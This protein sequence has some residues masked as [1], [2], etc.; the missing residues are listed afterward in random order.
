MINRRQLMRTVGV[1]LPAAVLGGTV[2][3][4][5]TPQ[6]D[7]GTKSKTAEGCE[8]PVCTPGSGKIIQWGKAA[9]AVPEAGL[10]GVT[11]VSAGA[12]ANLY[13]LM[14]KDGRVAIWGSFNFST[15]I[16]QRLSR[17]PVAAT[18]DV[19]A[20]ATASAYSIALR[21]GGVIVW[22][23]TSDLNLT[24]PEA[25]K[26]G[27]TAI[28]G[29]NGGYGDGLF[30]KDGGVIQWHGRVDVPDEAKEGIVAIAARAHALALREDGRVITWGRDQAANMAVPAE[31]QSGVT[32]ISAGAGF[33]LAIKN[34]GV[35]A[36]G[37]NSKGQLEVPYE[38]QSDVVAISAG[39]EASMALTASGKIVT[40]AYNFN[41]Q[42]D[43]PAEAQCGGSAISCGRICMVVL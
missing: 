22:G 5:S 1:G 13:N 20:I 36:W 24:L 35:I 37:D 7:P 43:I 25:A 4:V 38:A 8:P 40:W 6:A 32:K 3:R 9:P 11:A 19:T 34:G 2:S 12:Y 28:A 39:I 17:V 14:L 33:T 31:A 42:M 21:D 18:K 29:G 41:G 23:G 15:P 26:S 27:V 30:L 10:S 16:E